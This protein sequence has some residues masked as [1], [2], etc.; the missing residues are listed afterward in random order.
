MVLF[1]FWTVRID[2]LYQKEKN[3]EFR[4]VIVY[5]QNKSRWVEGERY[6]GQKNIPGVFN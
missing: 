1:F 2:D 4:L 5:M 3:S 6:V